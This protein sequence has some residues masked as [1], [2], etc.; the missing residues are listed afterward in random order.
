VNKTTQQAI[1]SKWLLVL[2]EYELIKQNKNKNIILSFSMR[3]E[4]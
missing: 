3:K 4:S 2:K 1:T